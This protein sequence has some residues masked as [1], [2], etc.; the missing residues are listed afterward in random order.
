MFNPGPIRIFLQVLFYSVFAA[1]I[2][3]FSFNPSYRQLVPGE[4]L[5]KLSFSHAGQHKQEC[6]R[7]S[8][9]EIAKL[10]PNMQHQ[11]QCSRERVPL[12]V[13]IHLDDRVLY[14]ELLPPAGLSKDG[15]S[16]V[17]KL[18]PVKSGEY[19]ITALLRD[20]RRTQGFD[21][22]YSE[23]VKLAP[24]QNFVID[25]RADTGGFRFL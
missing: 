10:A 25:F 22:V 3:Y 24:N 13:E 17:Y 20:S 1:G 19:V 5:I 18:F 7:L 2:G 4:A 6:R 21:Y 9:E 12:L 14:H 15:E 11:M 23:K 8:P 16:T